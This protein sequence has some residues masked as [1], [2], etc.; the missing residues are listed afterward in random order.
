MRLFV[1]QG[2]TE[3]DGQARETVKGVLDLLNDWPDVEITT[4]CRAQDGTTFRQTFEAE[5]GILF[6][7]SA[8]RRHRLRLLRQSDAM[9]VIRTGLS[10]STAFE[11]AHNVGC[12]PDLPMLFAVHSSA[13]IRTTLLQDLDE[14]VPA[15]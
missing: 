11:V 9:V 12:G 10:E 3:T 1:R 2:F 13:P 4:G 8:F 15:T 7:P 5:N 14:S 6:S